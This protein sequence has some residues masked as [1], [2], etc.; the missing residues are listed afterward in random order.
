LK[1]L[2]NQSSRKNI[3]R[4]FIFQF[5]IFVTVIIISPAAFTETIGDYYLQLQKQTTAK[6]FKAALATSLRALEK[7]P[8]QEGFYIY[9]IWSYRETKNFETAMELGKKALDHFPDSK[10]IKENLSYVYAFEAARIFDNKLPADPLPIA[11]K[12]LDFQKNG[13][14]LL[15]YGISLKHNGRLQEA[16]TVFSEGKTAYPD[17]TYFKPNLV[18]TL[19]DIAQLEK[20]QKKS[21]ALI[22]KAY[23]EDPE[24]EGALIWYGISNRRN[25]NFDT[26]IKIFS[27]GISKFPENRYFHENLR[28]TYTEWT[29]KLTDSNDVGHARK[30]LEDAR[31]L[32]PDDPFIISSLAYTYFRREHKKWEE[33]CRE[34]I[35]LVPKEK[36][37]AM[38][39]Y[40][41]PL[42]SERIF[43]H[44]GNMEPVT[45][46]GIGN[47]FGFDLVI[48]DKNNNY[49][50]S[51]PKKEDHFIYNAPVFAALDGTVKEIND[52]SPDS[53]PEKNLPYDVNFIRIEHA[54]GES[55]YYMHLQKN[56]SIVK[57]G[58]PVKQGQL[59]AKVGCSGRYADF[60]HLHFQV[61]R[62]NICVEF[63]FTG[64]ELLSGSAKNPSNQPFTPSKKDIIRSMRE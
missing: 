8:D 44:Q 18:Y 39:N 64:T 20:D 4:N 7:H 25:R 16:C 62:D 24:N 10:S 35:A 58:D 13:T 45:H 33:L 5:I 63:K 23:T 29:V 19:L 52:S 2:L 40:Q 57:I 14:T 47:G 28:W 26:A 15:W 11:R 43:I 17:I 51:W 50:S 27:T 34:S 48:V 42:K 46:L 3:L 41:M 9:A 31:K 61:M 60:P 38:N 37:K 59:I 32:L 30:L 53:E 22:L 56:S 55:S 21:D 54:N 1:V 12:G 6:D 49:W 36:L